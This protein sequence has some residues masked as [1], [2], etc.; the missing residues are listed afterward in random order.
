MMKNVNELINNIDCCGCEVCASVCPKNAIYFVANETG[1]IYPKINDALCVKCGLCSTKCP[2]FNQNKT[3]CNKTI[4][5]GYSLDEALVQKSSSGGFFSLIARWFLN[6]GG[7]VFGVSWDDD[8]FG[9]KHV[10]VKSNEELDKIIGSKY[11]QSKKNNVYSEVLSFLAEGK[12]VLFSGTPCEI[13]ALDSVVPAKFKDNL[14]TIDLVCHGP[15]TPKALFEYIS[16]MELKYH[17][18]ID[19]LNMRVPIG[20]WIP[21]HFLIRFKNGKS[22]LDRLY[23]T[24]IGDAVRIIQRPSCYNCSFCGD[25]R[26]A[27]I[28]LGDYHGAKETDSFYHSSGVSIAISHSLKGEQMIGVLQS[29]NAYVEDCS[30]ERIV[31]H[32]PRIEKPWPPLPEYDAFLSSFQKRGLFYA[33][34]KTISLKRKIFRKLPLKTRKS[35]ERLWRK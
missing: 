20:N 16:F 26:K 21:Q 30:Y 33:S 9:T 7:I 6:N 11:F 14:F 10:S 18:D 15:S 29:S 31:K 2:V 32:N 8:F 24:Q 25:G 27:D 5:C 23:D 34:K 12:K 19:Y 22:R 17:S 4:I 13:A 28:T 35:I 1:F 3:S